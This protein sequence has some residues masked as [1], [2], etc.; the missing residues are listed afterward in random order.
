MLLNQG[1]RPHT[2]LEGRRIDPA[3]GSIAQL[4]GVSDIGAAKLRQFLICCRTHRGPPPKLRAVRSSDDCRA[5]FVAG[6]VTTACDVERTRR[7]VP[8]KSEAEREPLATGTALTT[9]A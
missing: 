9:S 1:G 7:F 3:S 6:Q 5:G 4:V 8:A 2:G